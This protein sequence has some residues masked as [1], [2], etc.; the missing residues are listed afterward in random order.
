MALPLAFLGQQVLFLARWRILEPPVPGRCL[1]AHAVFR[2][3]PN[4][5]FLGKGKFRLARIPHG[6][7]REDKRAVLLH[8]REELRVGCLVIRCD[9]RRIVTPVVL[10]VVTV[11]D[12]RYK[13][14][15]PVRLRRP[16]GDAATA[17]RITATFFEIGVK[18]PV[19]RRIAKDTR[20]ILGDTRL[21]GFFGLVPC[22]PC[23]MACDALDGAS[24][25]IRV[26]E[27]RM[28]AHPRVF[29]D[30]SRLIDDQAA[31]Q[32]CREALDSRRQR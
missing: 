23:R 19:I 25:N 27:V 7:Q 16:E 28:E 4:E 9:S 13:T 20:N 6:N 11:D 21:F 18:P 1:R 32:P 30:A 24:R 22:A 10:H 14:R 29:E 26:A 8:R 31:L 3:G 5:P 12:I 17:F 2:N 15:L